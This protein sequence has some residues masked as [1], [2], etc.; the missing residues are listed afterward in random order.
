MSHAPAPPRRAGGRATDALR[1]VELAIDVLKYAEGSVEIAMGDTRVL[2]AASVENR[3]PG[4]LSGSGRGWVT[5]EYAMLP[6]ATA[7]RSAREVTQ[8][9]PSG[10]T[11]EIQRLVG[12]SLRSV[13]DLA[14]LGERTVTVDCDVLQ[15][16][17]GTRCAAITG[18]WVATALALGKIYLAG[19]VVAWPLA[20]QVAAVSVGVVGGAPLLDLDFSED[21]GADVD[22]NV[23]ATPDGRLVEI[24]GTG[25]HRSFSRAELDQLIDLALAGIAR[26]GGEQRA[27]VS[28][29]LAEVAE[30]EKKGPR[31]QAPPKNERG[32]WKRDR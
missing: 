3:V 2:V 6:R 20:D 24:Q 26:L 32:L 29:L 9:R 1:P 22:M 14:K 23:V 30:L 19:D 4:F 18:A 21:Q 25:E 12:R 31:R 15:A 10:R 8:G 7:T 17:A 5:A 27:A 11:A 16:D 13:V 28:T